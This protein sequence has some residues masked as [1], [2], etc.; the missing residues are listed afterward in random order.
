[1]L[2]TTAP[3]RPPR[4]PRR[5]ALLA[6][7][8]PL[9]AASCSASGDAGAAPAPTTTASVSVS[10]SQPASA[11]LVDVEVASGTVPIL[12]ARHGPLPPLPDGA[13]SRQIPVDGHDVH[14]IEIPG[15]GPPVVLLHGFPDNL[16]LYDRLYPL[17]DGRRVIAFDF[18]GWGRSAKPDPATFDYT[19][20]AQVDQLETVLDAYDVR[21]AT[22]VIHDQSAPVGLELLRTRPTDR[23]GKVVLLNGFYAP[24]P[25]LT[26]PKGIEIH[27]DPTLQ[28]VEEAVEADLAAV[29]AF[30]RFQMGE[31]IV[32][33]TPEV[34][35]RAIDALWS[36]FPE[37]R[38]AFIAMN[39]VL[40][41][42]VGARLDTVD[43]LRAVTLP[44]AI[45]YGAQDP[46]LSVGTAREFHEI[47]PSST[48]TVI[49]DAGHFV[50]IDDPEAVARAILE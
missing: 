35:Q 34:E 17:L 14:A 6:L 25:F 40:Y 16:H 9:A 23:L 7:L 41:A 49:E 46:Y 5:L 47:F 42:E 50:Q 39:D 12:P 29:E 44:V 8:L 20:A 38:P 30:Y 26:P 22:L 15:E 2:A 27:A 21:D 37:A 32:K 11:G 19:T 3:A 45:V 43:E 36:A 4:R 1:M 24:S 28:P 18:L 33:A 13:R 48:L 31:F 10:V